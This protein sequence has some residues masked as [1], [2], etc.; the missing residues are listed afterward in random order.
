MAR[1]MRQRRT[2]DEFRLQ[3]N[4]RRATSHVTKRQ[5]DEF[6]TEENKKRAEALKIE[7]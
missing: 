2:D 4:R 6:R 3:D 5:N 7:R 1:R